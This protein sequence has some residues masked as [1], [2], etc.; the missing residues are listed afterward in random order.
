MMRGPEKD[1]PLMSAI[2]MRNIDIVQ[3]LLGSEFVDVN[4]SNK[5]G[6]ND[7]GKEQVEA[8]KK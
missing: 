4:I 6:N 1:T 7:L 5:K 3:T 2:C 8:A